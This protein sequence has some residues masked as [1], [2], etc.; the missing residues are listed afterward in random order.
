MRK[1]FTR[2]LSKA[3]LCL[4]VLL[5]IL[6]FA[7]AQPSNP[8]DGPGGPI[9]VISSASNPFSRY[10]VEIL[11]AEGLNAF[12]A[13]DITAVSE[14]GLNNYDVAILGEMPLD[15]AQVT[16]LNNWVNNGGTLIAMRPDAQLQSLLGIT[17]AAGTLSEAYLLVNTSTGPGVGIVDQTIQYHGT[18]DLYT[19]NGA[20][21]LATLYANAFCQNRRVAY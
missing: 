11:R 20:T 19:L 13:T 10:P 3:L 5:F 18:A 17:P 7:R 4:S 9:L 1:I 14:T 15:A 8:N 21:A 16:I 12:D 2:S 6:A